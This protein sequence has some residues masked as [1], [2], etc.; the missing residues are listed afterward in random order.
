MSDEPKI[1]HVKGRYAAMS[2]DARGILILLGFDGVRDFSKRT[3]ISRHTAGQILGTVKLK[4]KHNYNVIVRCH[5]ALHTAYME[6][7]AT[8]VRPTRAY[9]VDWVK[10]WQKWVVG[11]ILRLEN[12]G[13]IKAPADSA[14][15]RATIRRRAGIKAGVVQAFEVLQWEV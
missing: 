5:E 10:R 2:S 3:G 9:I 14:D 15:G 7:R 1:F 6:Q 13:K 8:M 11:E 4:N 12:P